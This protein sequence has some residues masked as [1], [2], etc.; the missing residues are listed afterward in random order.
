MKKLLLF[1]FLSI[2]LL[3]CEKD[4]SLE[5]DTGEQHSEMSPTAMVPHHIPLSSRL[6]V[7][8]PETSHPEWGV[9]YADESAGLTTT[10]GVDNLTIC[11]DPSGLDLA[12]VQ[13]ILLSSN[14]GGNLGMSQ[15][16]VQTYVYKGVYSGG[17]FCSFIASAPL[18]AKGIATV[19]IT[20]NNLGISFQGATKY[21]HSLNYKAQGM[22]SSVYGEEVAFNGHFRGVWDGLD[23]S[24]FKFQVIVDM[25]YPETEEFKYQQHYEGE[26]GAVSPFKSHKLPA[27]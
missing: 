4:D 19:S 7:Y 12:P 16:E 14:E 22:L 6:F 3:A 18:E 23:P 10:H 13:E 27:H 11:L 5:P 8:R 24:T 26:K 20:H 15:G 9:I 25:R 2:L 21:S 17:D 1:S